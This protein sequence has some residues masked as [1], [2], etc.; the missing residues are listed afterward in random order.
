[1]Q[2]FQT[3][4]KQILP[5]EKC[6]KSC[7]IATIVDDLTTELVSLASSTTLGSRLVLII[8]ASFKPGKNIMVNMS[9][10]HNTNIEMQQISC[11]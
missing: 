7:A 11:E 6:C 9:I 10:E 2:S 8:L 5:F 1:M 4:E 3:M